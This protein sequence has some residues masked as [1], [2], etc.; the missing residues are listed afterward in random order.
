MRADDYTTTARLQARIAIHRLGTNPVPWF[1]FVRARVPDVPRL[2]DVGA[3][4]GALW[5]APRAGLVLADASPAM[6]ATQRVAGFASV[7]ARAEALPFA[8][9][10]FDAALACHMLYHLAE[11][12]AGLAELRRVVRPG[13][14]VLVATNGVDHMAELFDIAARAGLP[15]EQPHAAFPAE[16]APGVVAD[17]FADVAVHRYDDTLHVPDAEPV[18]AYLAPLDA[19]EERAVRAL[20]TAPLTIRKHTVLVTGRRA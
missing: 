10:A 5:P 3:G 14:T 20:V 19:D 2:L 15:A 12:R 17:Y 7:N 8:E 11:P 1:D 6:C 4:T 9:G 18:V 16:R 13:G